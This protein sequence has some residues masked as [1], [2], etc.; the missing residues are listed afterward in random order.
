VVGQVPRSKLVAE[1]AADDPR[2]PSRCRIRPMR[3]TPHESACR[4]AA[5]TN[6]PIVPLASRAGRATIAAERANA[7][8]MPHCA[9]DARPCLHRARAAGLCRTAYGK[10]KDPP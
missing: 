1:L 9:R 4:D 6:I 10:V 8:P 2:P 3:G 5:L 7:R